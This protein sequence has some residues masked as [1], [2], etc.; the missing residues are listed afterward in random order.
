MSL[1]YLPGAHREGCPVL[2]RLRKAKPRWMEA[3]A[4]FWG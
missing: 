4:E 3:G 2:E 1:G